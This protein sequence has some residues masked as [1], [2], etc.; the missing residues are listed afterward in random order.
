MEIINNILIPTDFSPAAWKAVQY[1][2]NLA[3]RFHANI[4]LLHVYPSENKYMTWVKPNNSEDEKILNDLKI[5]LKDFTE[6]LHI[7]NGTLIS[8]D[9][10]SG[11]VTRE[12]AAFAKER[13]FD[14]I[15]MGVNSGS[16]HNIPGSHTAE[17]IRNAGFPVLIIPNYVTEVQPS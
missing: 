3:K 1:G 14:L 4:T 13:K 2:L 16:T 11:N 7:S 6:E 5:K 8:Y 9:V 17:V 10:K 15:I 12:I